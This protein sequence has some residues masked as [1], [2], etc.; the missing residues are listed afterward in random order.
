M[1][2]ASDTEL[3]KVVYFMGEVEFELDKALIKGEKLHLD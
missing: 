2:F 1:S 3:R